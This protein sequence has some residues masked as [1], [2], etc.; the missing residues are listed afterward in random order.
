MIRK[1]EID[2]E[3]NVFHVY[4]INDDHDPHNPNGGIEIDCEDEEASKFHQDFQENLGDFKDIYKFENGKF[5]KNTLSKFQ[6]IKP[7]GNATELASFDEPPK[8]GFK[9]IKLLGRKP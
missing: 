2:E 9:H 7:E 4:Q 5:K 3:G 1:M 8:T 6:Q